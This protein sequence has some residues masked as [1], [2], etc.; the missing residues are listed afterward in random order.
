[1]IRLLIIKFLLFVAL[2][3]NVNGISI[4]EYVLTETYGK[5]FDLFTQSNKLYN[6]NSASFPYPRM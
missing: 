2:F 5:R 4:S 1:M 3:N 6:S